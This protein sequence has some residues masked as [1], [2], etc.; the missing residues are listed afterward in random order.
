MVAIREVIP[1]VLENAVIAGFLLPVMSA[2]RRG[3]VTRG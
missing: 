3:R 1:G 2:T